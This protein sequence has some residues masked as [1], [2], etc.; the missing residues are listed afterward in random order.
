MI[1][2]GEKHMGIDALVEKAYQ[3]TVLMDPETGKETSLDQV[4][5]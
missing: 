4:F 5:N 1:L 2:S 3:N